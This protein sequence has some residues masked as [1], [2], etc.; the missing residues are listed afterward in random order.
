M[1]HCSYGGSC[2]DVLHA[3]SEKVLP[4][5]TKKRSGA[6]R[7]IL[8]LSTVRTWRA[9]ARPATPGCCSPSCCDKASAVAPRCVASL[10]GLRHFDRGGGRLVGCWICLHNTPGLP[11]AC[12]HQLLPLM[13]GLVVRPAAGSGR[14]GLASCLRLVEHVV[15]QVLAVQ[16]LIVALADAG[17]ALEQR[18]AH[19]VDGLTCA[20]SSRSWLGGE[21]RDKIGSGLHFPR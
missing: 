1:A 6:R 11:P 20:K 2:S 10:S 16:L 18:D 17:H 12:D 3:H 7:P 8:W 9:S 19:W 13:T 21:N 15:V 5:R 4:N 14:D